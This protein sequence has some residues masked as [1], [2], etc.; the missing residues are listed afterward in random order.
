M[1]EIAEMFSKDI[2]FL[3]VDFYIINEQIYLGEFT[4]FHN[5]GSS[6]FNPP[7]WDDIMGEWLVLPEIK[8]K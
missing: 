1:V 3:R 6:K 8:G 4:F 5:S 7:E 2:L